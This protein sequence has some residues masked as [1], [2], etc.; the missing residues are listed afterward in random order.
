M[1]ETEPTCGAPPS[2]A[3]IKKYHVPPCQ[4]NRVPFVE[5]SK[6]PDNLKDN[7]LIIFYHDEFDNRPV[8]SG[9]SILSIEKVQMAMNLA[10]TLQHIQDIQE[11]GCKIPDWL[12]T[13][14]ERIIEHVA[15]FTT[16]S[17]REWINNFTKP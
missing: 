16:G 9:F 5:I 17:P 1:S 7:Q 10:E 12:Q 14:I 3:D 6:A 2:R 8:L 15:T 13:M 4:W 11:Q